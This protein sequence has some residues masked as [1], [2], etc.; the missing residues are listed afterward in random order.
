MTGEGL[1]VLLAGV[2]VLI[3]AYLLCAHDGFWR[4]REFLPSP[5]QRQD[6]PDIVALVP[7]RDEAATI[8]RTVRGILQQDYPGRLHLIV[9]DD[10]SGDGTA[11]LAREAAAGMGAAE[12]LTVHE[13]ETPPPG[14]T[15]K[16][17]ALAQGRERLTHDARPATYVW[18]SDADIGHGPETLR[19]LV[20]KAETDDRDLVSLMVKLKAEGFWGRLLI[21]SFILFFRMLYPFARA[22]RPD[23]REAAAAGGCILLRKTAL[24]RAGGFGAISGSLIDDCALATLV[25]AKGRAEA[26]RIWIG[27]ADD[28]ESLRAYDGLGGIWAMVSR[29]AYAQL[30]HSPALLLGT[31]IAMAWVFVLPPTTT[32]T[33]GFH[34]VPAAAALGA[35]GW[36]AMAVTCVPVLRHYRQA[37]AWGLLLPLS[38]ALYTA[39]TVGSAIAHARGRGG[40]WKGR[41]HSTVGEQ[42]RG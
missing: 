21:P 41:L 23:R 28:S 1:Y 17:W 26:G 25:K 37:P 18:L 10:Q 14:W 20:I 5:V 30:R 36:I 42:T 11:R 4:L 22:N 16:L 8:A 7:A 15:G 32:V 2:P 9:I 24:D 33:L 19:R 31:L 38:A 6:W 13:G 3:W 39:M 27:Q 29:S 12:R 35:V 40:R 34:G